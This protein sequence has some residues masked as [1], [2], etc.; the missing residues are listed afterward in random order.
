VY[1]TVS[2][3]SPERTIRCRMEVTLHQDGRTLLL[4]A[5]RLDQPLMLRE[6]APSPSRLRIVKDDT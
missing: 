2:L 6:P 1:G 5:E 4:R 3:S